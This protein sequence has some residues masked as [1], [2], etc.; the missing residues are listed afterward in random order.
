[1]S[2]YYDTI[3]SLEIRSCT[4]RTTPRRT[5]LGTPVQELVVRRDCVMSLEVVICTSAADV[6]DDKILW[7]HSNCAYGTPRWS[8]AYSSPNTTVKGPWY[9]PKYNYWDGKYLILGDVSHGK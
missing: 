9:R 2:T 3:V 4:K 8:N 6:M 5:I 7:C 1:M